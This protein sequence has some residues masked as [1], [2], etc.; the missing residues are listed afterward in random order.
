MA[1]LRAQVVIPYFTGLPADVITNT[2]YF[3]TQEVSAG[4]AR[5]ELTGALNQFYE[6]I[7]DVTGRAAT[8]VV[9]SDAEIRWYD[10]A[11]PEPRV[12]IIIPFPIQATVAHSPIPCECAVVLSFHGDYVPGIS[13]ASQRG[14]VYLGGLSVGWDASG[15]MSS[16]PQVEPQAMTDIVEAAEQLAVTAIF[17]GTRWCV[18]SPTLEQTFNVYGGWCDNAWDTQRRRGVPATARETF[19]VL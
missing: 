11:E 12:P 4:E 3:D 6:D 17:H 18:Y 19:G 5:T 10:M 13:R 8:H 1:I 9:W 2:F 14:R 7:Y 16:F 15:S